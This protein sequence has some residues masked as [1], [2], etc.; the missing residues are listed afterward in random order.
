[1]TDPRPKF[2]FKLSHLY[3][4]VI[5]SVVLVV[6]TTLAV[7]LF[8][9]SRKILKD[10]TKSSVT[11]SE[12]DL[13]DQL[14]KR[15]ELL[16]GFAAEDLITPLYQFQMNSIAD[17]LKT[18][19]NQEDVVY[20]YVYDPSGRILHDGTKKSAL[21]NNVLE[22][23]TSKRAVASTTSILV[24]ISSNTLDVAAPI[25]LEDQLLGGLRIGFSLSGIK[26]EIGTMNAELETLGNT[27]V[28]RS[29]KAVLI[30]TL[31]L[32][33]LGIMVSLVVA[34]GLSRPIHL[35]SD[36]A[37]QLGD[38]NYDV[39]I[40]IQRQDEIGQLV[41]AF[42]QMTT[43]LKK[44]TAMLIQAEKLAGI[45]QMAAGVA[46]EIAKPLTAIYGYIQIINRD[47]AA[48][49]PH[50]EKLQIVEQQC[51]RM[52]EILDNIRTF[53]RQSKSKL[54]PIDITRPLKEAL[55]LLEPQLL[56]NHVTVTQQIDD[57]LPKFTADSNQIQQV[58]INL[59]AN[60]TDAMGGKA[61]SK[62]LVSARQSRD[63]RYPKENFIEIIIK[64]NGPGIP[65][66][67]IGKIF[68][69]FFTTKG[70]DKGTGLGLSV[71]Y[72]IIKSHHGTITASSP[73]GEGAVFTIT[74]PITQPQNPGTA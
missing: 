42:N 65:E 1:M 11:L 46:H 73:P 14:K 74:L 28:G 2:A 17:K 48:P 18:L 71:T 61:G 27:G 12:K 34:R 53:S 5:V 33:I 30:I 29:R 6:V 43:N 49:N 51:A 55:M 22:D 72:G 32:V 70:E 7:T 58:L 41:H 62:I 50:K 21:I 8:V 24:Q 26:K 44:A 54:E 69:P 59:I 19:K 67:V 52:A 16:A 10:L 39:Q 47:S 68:D 4:A 66:N 15:A 60:A 3:T 31:I 37:R 56:K 9:N 13:L 45:G 38:G 35:L 63:K 40:P 25:R 36:F 57:N 20:T 64:D 23:G